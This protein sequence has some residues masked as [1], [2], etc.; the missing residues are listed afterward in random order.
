MNNE[1]SVDRYQIAGGWFIAPTIMLKAE[2]VNQKY[3]NFPT[4]D[5]RS[6]G[7]FKGLVFEGVVSF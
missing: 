6:G 5:I 4:T 3:N 7:K 2:Y 1:V